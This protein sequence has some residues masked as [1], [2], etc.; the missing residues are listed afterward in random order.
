MSVTLFYLELE[1]SSYNINDSL[2]FNI[3]GFTCHVLEG[4]LVSKVNKENPLKLQE[5][6]IS[7]GY[8]Y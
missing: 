3:Y 1:T 8:F 5:F 2:H 6:L 4:L 7:L